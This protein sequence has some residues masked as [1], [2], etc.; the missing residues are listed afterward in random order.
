MGAFICFGSGVARVIVNFYMLT[1]LDSYSLH[2][3]IFCIYL[4]CLTPLT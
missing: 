2:A 3:Y 1:F 4:D